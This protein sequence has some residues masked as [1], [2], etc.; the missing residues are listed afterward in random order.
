VLG[1]GEQALNACMHKGR[2]RGAC[3]VQW[4]TGAMCMDFLVLRAGSVTPISDSTA[5]GWGRAETAAAACGRGSGIGA[6]GSRTWTV[7]LK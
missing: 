4:H 3:T 2:R 5:P 6:R 7:A 1:C